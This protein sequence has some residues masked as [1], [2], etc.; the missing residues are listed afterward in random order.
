[1]KFNKEYFSFERQNPNDQP[2]KDN[3]SLGHGYYLHTLPPQMMQELKTSVDDVQN[4]FSKAVSYTEHLVGKIDHEYKFDFTPNCKSYLNNVFKDYLLASGLGRKTANLFHTV[5]S[6]ESFYDKI[7]F[8]VPDVWVNFQLKHE[9]NPPHFHAGLF[10]FVIWYQIP[11]THDEESKA[12]P[13]QYSL[14][15]GKHVSHGDFSF[16][17]NGST[18]PKIHALNIDSSW[19]GNICIF[20]SKLHHMVYPFYSSDDPRITIAG[21]VF[22]KP[23]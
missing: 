11:F 15:E 23:I 9:Y 8:D 4:N 14:G 3:G 22:L 12:G 16:L 21:N 13:G 20:P 6:P 5:S 7:Y 1:M 2:I 19:N 18:G 17:F 10:S